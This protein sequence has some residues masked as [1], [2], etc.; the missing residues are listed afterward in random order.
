MDRVFANTIRH[1]RKK[2]GLS[3]VDTS[4]FS[5]ISQSQVSKLEDGSRWPMK[6]TIFW[7]CK[8]FGISTKEFFTY[9]K[10]DLEQQL[11]SW[12]EPDEDDYYAE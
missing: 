3:Q 10:D 8:T 9:M 12:I 5:G 2:A 1:F 11:K 7:L 4:V 6:K